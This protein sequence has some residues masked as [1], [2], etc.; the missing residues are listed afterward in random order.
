M[1]SPPTRSRCESRVRSTPPSASAARAVAQLD[2]EIDFC[3]QFLPKAASDDEVKAIVRETIAKLGVSDAKQSGRV[4]CE[5]MK[6]HKGK[7]EPG[8]VKRSSKQARAQGLTA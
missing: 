3:A 4:V 1:W 5:I 7:V 6:A 8:A 2:F